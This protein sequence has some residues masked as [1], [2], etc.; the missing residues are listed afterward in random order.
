M[1]P[2]PRSRIPSMTLRVMLKIEAR[3]TWITS[4]HCSSLI[5]WSMASRVMPALLTSTS[6]GPSSF[7]TLATAAAQSAKDETLPLTTKAPS[8][9]AQ[10]WAAT[11]LPA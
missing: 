8:S 4:F 3:F 1:R 11:S 10:A 9:V 5:L 2:K 7:S 6:I